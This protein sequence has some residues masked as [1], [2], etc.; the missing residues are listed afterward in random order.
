MNNLLL[1]GINITRLEY[2]A[3]TITNK[4]FYLMDYDDSSLLAEAVL[5]RKTS[6][7]NQFHLPLMPYI[8]IFLAMSL[9]YILRIAVNLLRTLLAGCIISRFIS[10]AL[11]LHR[12]YVV[13]CPITCFFSKCFAK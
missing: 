2:N 10:T 13:V 5:A 6:Y 11:S 8:L 1:S 12:I 3:I 4:N 7:L 9:T